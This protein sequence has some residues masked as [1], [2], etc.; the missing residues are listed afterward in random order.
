M[1]PV[2]AAWYHIDGPANTGL[3]TGVAL[4]KKP[5]DFDKVREV[6]RVRLAGFDR[7]RQRVVEAGFPLATPH[8]EDM[9]HF[10]IDQHIHRIAL[11][12]PHDAAALKKLFTDLASAPLDHEQ[13]LWQIHVVDNVGRGSALVMRYHHCIGDGTALQA[14][15]RKVFDTTPDAP[16]EPEDTVADASKAKAGPLVPGFDAL[17]RAARRAIGLGR[18]AI[19]AVA[20]PQRALDQAMLLLGG[21]GVLL[22]ELVKTPDPPSPFKGDFGIRKSVAWSRP[23]AVETVKA[24]GAPQGAKVNDVLVAAM[25]GAL[26]S[27]LQRRG[28]EVDH[29]TVRAMV[30]VDLRPPERVGLLGNDFGL[31]VLE[32]AVAE[33]KALE[34]V[35]T[36]KARMDK[37]KRSP[38]PVAMKFLFDLFG[39]GPKALEDLA[40][41][42]FGS[43][44]SVVMTNVVGPKDTMY[45]AGVPIDQMMFWV[46]HPGRQLGMGISILSYRGMA[47]LAVIA[48]AGLVPD[49][50]TITDEFNREFERMK[51]AALRRG[52]TGDA[53]ASA[54][55]PRAARGVARVTAPRKA[56]ARA[57]GARA[58]APAARKS[59]TA[60]RRAAG[61][62]AKRPPR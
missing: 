35:A 19:D 42:I 10:D 48:D 9:P 46:P 26:R 8:W 47:S 4:T 13:P 16:L 45:L 11:P 30:P 20:H 38:E 55:R 56:P 34:R 49:P 5:L 29:T 50:E 44:A 60:P 54:D 22:T 1:D 14:V 15:V 3:V 33:P 17:E 31:V 61:E 2:D 7:F 37:L 36:T 25:T 53:A 27:Y 32:L 23:V 18:D 41:T 39:R 52:A 6:Y 12:A 57:A 28:V 58:A 59:S 51:R 62:R 43:K 24:I 40:N 21:A